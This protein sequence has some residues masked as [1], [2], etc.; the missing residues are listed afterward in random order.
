MSAAKDLD[1]GLTFFYRVVL[2]GVLVTAAGTP[3]ALGYLGLAGIT[4]TEA[5][6][7]VGVSA[8]AVIGVL[9]SALDDPIY[10]FFEGRRGWPAPLAGWLTQ[11][12]QKHVTHLMELAEAARQRKDNATYNEIYYELR[13]FPEDGPNRYTASRPTKLGNILA[14]YE[15][16]SERRYGMDSIFYWPRL[17]LK[18]DK[19]T[20]EEVDRTWASTDSL[21]YLA[22][23]MLIVGVLYVI[24][25]LVSVVALGLGAVWF[26]ATPDRQFT[27]AAAGIALMMLAYLP[28]RFSIS[29]HL[30]NGDYFKSLFDLYRSKL[31]PDLRV[32]DATERAGWRTL[33]AALQYGIPKGGAAMASKA[34]SQQDTEGTWKPPADDDRP[35][36]RPVTC[37]PEGTPTGPHNPWTHDDPAGQT[38]AWYDPAN[39]TFKVDCGA[40]FS[41]EWS[42]LCPDA[43]AVA[44]NAP[45]P[46]PCTPGETVEAVTV[47]SEKHMFWRETR[48]A[49]LIICSIE[50]TVTRQTWACAA[51]DT[52][53]QPVTP[54]AGS[55]GHWKRDGSATSKVDAK[56]RST[57]FSCC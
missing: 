47:T 28:Y 14:S 48:C 39:K 37:G 43:P 34:T 52:I 5:Q 8:A 11:R 44:V 55:T 18:L 38:P 27:Y 16:Y 25:A 6:S 53:D 4:V 50:W 49:L 30:T 33:W 29:G 45:A 17:W 26:P 12:W 32:P 20:R 46:G 15:D 51:D 23:G 13:Q 31:T 2:P 10:Q 21:M 35:R 56:H 9:L 22:A 24:T 19:D 40:G 42:S 3:L 1:F 54:N 41:V 57:H 7:W 36:W